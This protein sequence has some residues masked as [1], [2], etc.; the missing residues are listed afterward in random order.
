MS[1]YDKWFEWKH[2]G[3]PSCAMSALVGPVKLS[4]SDR[5]L[6]KNKYI[7][8]A[9]EAA[10]TCQDLLSVKYEELLDRQVNE[11]REELHLNII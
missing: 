3:L 7:P 11:L 6:L 8:W 9:N 2:T 4:S 1:I 5:Y 10:T